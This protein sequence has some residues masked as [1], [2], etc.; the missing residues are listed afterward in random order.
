MKIVSLSI[1]GAALIGLIV[2]GLSLHVPHADSVGSVA[3]TN[4]FVGVMALAGVVYLGACALVLRHTVQ[5]RLMLWVV[6]G[7]ALAMRLPVLLAPP[8]LSSDVYRYVWDGRVQAAGINPYR[9][10]PAD[11][12]LVRLRDTAIYPHINRRTYAR[13]IY[14]PMAQV[15]Y[16]AIAAFAQSVW[17]VKVAMVGFECLAVVC[18]I[19]LLRMA[20]LPDTRV[21]IYAWNPLAVWA[22]AGNG[23][24]DAAAAGLIAAA[25]LARA[26][27][28]DTLAGAVLAAATLVKFFPL[29]IAPALWRP[30]VRPVNWQA[31]V[32]FLAVVIALYACYIQVGWH[33]LGFLPHYGSEEGLRQ[34]TGVW[35]LDGIA[36]VC[37]LPSW[38]S[39]AYLAICASGLVAASLWLLARNRAALPPALDVLRLCRQAGWLGFAFMLLLSPHYPWYFPFLAVFATIAPSRAVIWL[40]VAPLLLY[41]DPIADLFIWRGL[42]FAPALLLAAR[43]LRVRAAKRQPALWSAPT[44]GQV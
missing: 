27:R 32:A 36:E 5:P 26:A 44:T 33:V 31:P 11:P 41:L 39:A 23:H 6:L 30:F 20:G 8:F 13:T 18:L 40:S 14:P 12:A 9:F 16:R 15:I 21:L 35:L 24:V 25:L 29:A 19:A 34:G 4:R 3:L 10:V 28:R 1:A 43:D 38:T 2:L 37:T 42:V 17:A 22:F 7:V